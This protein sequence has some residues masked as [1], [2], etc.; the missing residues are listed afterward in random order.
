MKNWKIATLAAGVALAATTAHA[1][2][3]LDKVKARGHIV[4]GASQG[5]VGFGSPDDKGYWTGLDVETCRAVAVAIFGDKDKVE[6]VPLSGQQ[7]IPAL[8]TGEIDILPRTLTW[9]LQRDANGIN[10]ATPTYYEFTGF[11][12]AKSS[13]VTKVE[14][15]TGAS[16][17]V[18]TGSTTEVVVNDVSS[19]L[20]LDLKP[21][22]FDNVAATRQAF[23]SG[24]CDALITDAAALASVRATQSDKPD[25]YVIFPATKY[26]DALTPAV[27]HGDD[28]W[29]D[30]VNWSIQALLN[31]ELY[32][33]TQ[34]N[35]DEMM[36]TDDP[37]VKRFLGVEPGNGK[38]LGLDDKFAYN[39]V[40]QLGNY[41]EVFDRNL[42]KGSAL[43]IERGPNKL[44]SDG[45]MMF[46]MAFQ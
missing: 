37:R 42:G 14:E 10:F 18:Q 41:G 36:T 39:I 21:V 25:D 15:M 43:K 11:M 32:G 28:N 7:R 9:T 45:G 44:F 19:K 38:A 16:V 1:G 13:G 6:F 8:Q 3:T 40:K 22:V 30:V 29:L 26:M 20:N 12:V 17:C 4:C 31:A 34:A 35:I 46:P 2:P 27:R 5:T 23:F 24:R 33:I